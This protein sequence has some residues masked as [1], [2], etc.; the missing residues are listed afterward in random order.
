[1]PGFQALEWSYF[2]VH[3]THVIAISDKHI[4]VYYTYIYIFPSFRSFLLEVIK[5]GLAFLLLRSVVEEG[6]LLKFMLAYFN[7][8]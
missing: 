8:I 4:Y 2:R 3:P 5:I 1:M 6:R 7:H